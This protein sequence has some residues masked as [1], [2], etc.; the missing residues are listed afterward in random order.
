[1]LSLSEARKIKGVSLDEAANY[2]GISISTME[3][4]ENNQNDFKICDAVMLAD[5]YEIDLKIIAFK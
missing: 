4:L 3:H 2:I 1:M 5:L